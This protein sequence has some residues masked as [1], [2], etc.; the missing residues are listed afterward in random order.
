MILFQLSVSY[1]RVNFNIKIIELVYNVRVEPYFQ[2]CM[3]NSSG[4]F[5]SPRSICIL[6]MHMENLKGRSQIPQTQACKVKSA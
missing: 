6:I 5:N 2:V 1:K 3:P 4:S